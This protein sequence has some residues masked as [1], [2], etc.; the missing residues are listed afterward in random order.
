MAEHFLIPYGKKYAS[1]Q[2]NV[3]CRERVLR[4]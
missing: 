2:W 3:S 4:K 1:A